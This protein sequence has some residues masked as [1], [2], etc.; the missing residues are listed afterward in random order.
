M[1]CGRRPHIRPGAACCSEYDLAAEPSPVII[2]G[3][4]A[5]G[6]AT[7]RS[8]PADCRCWLGRPAV[9]D[10]PSDSASSAG[11]GGGPSASGSIAGFPCFLCSAARTSCWTSA[12]WFP[13]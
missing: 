8:G 10:W 3:L 2:A 12:G 5:P 13:P 4:F 11:S 7:G 1:P 6:S 9:P